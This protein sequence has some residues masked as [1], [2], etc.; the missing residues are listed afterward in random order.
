MST[1]QVRQIYRRAAQ[2]VVEGE[3]AR[4]A[5]AAWEEKGGDLTAAREALATIPSSPAL[6]VAQGDLETRQGDL[7]AALEFYMAAQAASST[8]TSPNISK[9]T[10]K[11]A[12]F[13]VHRMNDKSEALNVIEVGL[14]ENESSYELYI[15]KLKIVEMGSNV[16]D[17]LNVCDEAIENVASAADK[18]YFINQKSVFHDI[19]GRDVKSSMSIKNLL[20]ESN[21]EKFANIGTTCDGC[22]ITFSS[23]K[24][25]KRHL[26]SHEKMH[27]CSK[28]L[29]KFTSLSIFQSHKS[30]CRFTCSVCG[31]TYVRRSDFI[32][33]VEK[34]KHRQDV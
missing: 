30:G 20:S 31:K 3:E 16:D 10:V 25:L 21:L 7:E 26:L 14:A 27:N 1:L 17:I 33:H 22:N 4:L 29:K 13:L 23:T 11:L 24:N 15:I 18:E 5:W 2:D 19:Y 28:C 32:K 9:V 6:H 8:V 12:H 34:L